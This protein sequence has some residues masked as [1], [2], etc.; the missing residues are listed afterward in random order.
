MAKAPTKSSTLTIKNTKDYI[1][2]GKIVEVKPVLYVGQSAGHGKYIAA[3]DMNGVV[4]T[5]ENGK[6]ISY[7]SL[8]SRK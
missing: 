7:R 5:D 1:K 6:P 3:C 4:V 2:N 8:E